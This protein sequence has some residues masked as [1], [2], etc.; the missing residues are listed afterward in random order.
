MIIIQSFTKNR[1]CLILVI[2]LKIR[3]YDPVNKK[4]IGKIKDEVRRNIINEFVTS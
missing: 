1:T 4:L 3:F 2:I